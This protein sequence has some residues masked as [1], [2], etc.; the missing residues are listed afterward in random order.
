[1]CH[2]LSGPG[3]GEYFVVRGPT[4]QQPYQGPGGYGLTAG[5]ATLS[6]TLRQPYPY[7]AR[8]DLMSEIEHVEPR[9]FV[10]PPLKV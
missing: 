10:E 4:L 7:I 3:T 5:L 1:M 6:L 9:E 2:L 8:S